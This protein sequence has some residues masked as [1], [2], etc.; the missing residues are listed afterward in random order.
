MSLADIE[1]FRQRQAELGQFLTPAPLADFMASMFGPLPS[2][3]RLLDAGAGAGAL[4]AAFVARCTGAKD[5]PVKSIEA[6]VYERD[7]RIL[8]DLDWTLT[9]CARSCEL[10]GI[11]FQVDVRREDFIEAAADELSGSLFSRKTVLFDAAIVNPPY[12]KIRNESSE[13]KTLRRAGIETVN[14]YSGFVGLILKLL[15][16]GGQLVAIT[17]RSFCNGPYYQPFRQQLVTSAGMQRIHVFESRT[18]AFRKD[19][20]LQENVVFHAIK[21]AKWPAEVIVSS[22]SGQAG[23]PVIERRISAED[24]VHPCDKSHFIHIPTAPAPRGAGGRLG[25]LTARLADIG[26]EVSTGRVVAYRNRE[27]LRSG[28]GPNAVPLIHPCHFGQPNVGWPGKAGRKPVAIVAN[29]QTRRWLIPAGIYVLTKRFTSKEQP[30]RLVTSLLDPKLVPASWFG[31]ENHV[32]YIHQAGAGL[33]RL[34]AQ[35]LHAWL[36]S[37]QVDQYFR[38]FS[39]HTQVNAADLRSLFYPD[40]NA[41]VG[42]GQTVL[43][44]EMS[45]P[46]IDSLVE[47]ILHAG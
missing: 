41:L 47:E 24:V 32:N 9:G 34:L 35:G 5:H 10:A 44:G 22:C 38:E 29:D 19:A 3:V 36:G 12:R 28:P 16:P 26:L 11:G 4:T 13:R 1:S 17:P 25:Q 20:V 46:A 43:S 30:R 45:Q 21:A 8:D 42:L 23:D 18:A 31:I 33:D 40:R 7:E 39:G 14:L 6:V 15:K 2:H 37:T 27:W